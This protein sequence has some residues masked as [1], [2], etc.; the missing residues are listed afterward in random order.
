MSDAKSPTLALRD[1]LRRTLRTYERIAPFYDLLDLVYE[2]SWKR[3]LRRTLFTFARGRLLDVGVGTGCNMP[4]YPPGSEAVG[5]DASAAML[6]RAERRARRLGR[7]VRLA[8]ADLLDLELDDGAF[9]TVVAT[10]VL[11][12]LPDSAQLRAL[13]ELARVCRGDGRILI[14]DY[15]E[16]SAKRHGL[17]QRLRGLW[18]DRVFAGRFDPPIERHLEAAG[19]AVEHRRTF[20]GASVLLLVLR[21]QDRGL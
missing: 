14:L 3:R 21:P 5:I 18:I 7:P 4:Y 19:L 11:L 6:E 16:A 13:R 10:F 12:C 17:W 8:R 20:L 9:D 2:L 15:Q 1:P